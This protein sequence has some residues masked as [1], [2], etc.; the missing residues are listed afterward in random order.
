MFKTVSRDQETTPALQAGYLHSLF[1]Q[2]GQLD[3]LPP[4]SVNPQSWDVSLPNAPASSAAPH[5]DVTDFGAWLTAFELDTLPEPIADGHNGVQD[6]SLAP[7]DTGPP[8]AG[9]N[10]DWDAVSLTGGRFSVAL[11]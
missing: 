3:H 1:A 2:G 4:M 11:G 9:G 5:I 6:V 8:A 7:H 10:S